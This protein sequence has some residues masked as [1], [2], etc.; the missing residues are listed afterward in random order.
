M[1]HFALQV[2]NAHTF[3]IK[4]I[5]HGKEGSKESSKEGDQESSSQEGS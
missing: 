4:P 2:M 3:D 5:H 1:V